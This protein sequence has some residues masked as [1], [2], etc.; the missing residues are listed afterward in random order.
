MAGEQRREEGRTAGSLAEAA[1][2]VGK[3]AQ[4]LGEL[5]PSRRFTGERLAPGL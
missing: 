2:L 1:V 4:H 3:Q 5:P